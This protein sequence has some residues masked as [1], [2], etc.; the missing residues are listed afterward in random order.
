[1]NSIEPSTAPFVFCGTGDHLWSHKVEPVDSPATL[2]ALCEWL[3]ETYQVKRL[4]WRGGQDDIWHRDFRRVSHDPA[5]Y[6]WVQWEKFLYDELE[7]N[8]AAVAA[9]KAKGMEVYLYTGLFEHGVQP[10]VGI[11]HPHVFEDT[12]RKDHPEWCSLDRWQQRRCPGPMCLGYPE[13]RKRIIDRLVDQLHRFGYDGITFYTYVENLGLRYE[14][15]FG[16]NPP[17]A[18]EFNKAYPEVDLGKDILTPGQKAH[19][20]KCQGKFVTDLLVE[21]HERMVPENKKLSMILDAAEPDYPQKWW[22]KKLHGTGKIFLEWEKWIEAGIVDEI[23][24]QLGMPEA[25]TALL[26]RLLIQCAGKPV[27]LTVRTPDP[28]AEVWIPYV[29]Q[30]V[31]PVAVITWENNG[32]EKISLG[33]T[34]MNTLQSPDWKLRAQTLADMGNGTMAPSI[35]SLASLVN[36]PE[37][38]VR[39]R[40]PRALAKIS[41]G[42]A[43]A[44]LEEL[45]TDPESSVR[46]AAAEALRSTPGPNTAR[47][48][49]EALEKGEHFQFKLVAVPALTAIGAN[50]VPLLLDNLN[51]SQ[52]DVS[53]VC[54][55]ALGETFKG[56]PNPDISQALRK[57]IHDDTADPVLRTWALKSLLKIFQNSLPNVPKGFRDFPEDLISLIDSNGAGATADLQLHA[58]ETLKSISGMMTASEKD[59]SLSVLAKAFQRYGDDSTRPDAAYGWRVIGNA[60]L[61]LQGRKLLEEML[62]QTDD[63][64]LAWNAYETVYLFHDLLPHAENPSFNEVDEKQAIEEHNL[65]APAFPGWRRW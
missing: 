56:S 37:V 2:A 18:E 28:F 65:H 35:T 23:W 46:I 61:I 40:L 38:L 13:V 53:E 49:I 64:W 10:D 33:P 27:Q 26:D 62:R 8:A 12:L 34:S 39:H 15:E 31:T 21:L 30:G 54:L 9:A 45:L 14:D 48:L 4:Y 59:S 43:T 24:V 50:A 55:R 22:G 47:R 41:G 32:V 52:A 16:F 3:T 57:K 44:M 36:D 7:L 5:I 6:D 19:W 17:I 42:K 63:K 20:Y 1:M 60:I 58:A 29:R 51:N 11:V 25:Q